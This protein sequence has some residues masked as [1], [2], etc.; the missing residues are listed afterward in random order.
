MANNLPS[1]HLLQFPNQRRILTLL[2]TQ[3]QRQI[4]TVHHPLDKPAPFRQH[5]RTVTLNQ[6][7]AA[8][9]RY[10]ALHPSHPVLLPVKTGYVEQRLNFEGCIGTEMYPGEGFIVSVRDEF[11]E[12][13]MLL[14]RDFLGFLGPHGLHGV[15]AFVI[16]VDRELDVIRIFGEDALDRGF[17]GVFEAVVLQL[18]HQRRSTRGGCFIF[19][20]I[21]NL[22]GANALR[23][24]HLRRLGGMFL[25]GRLG[26]HVHARPH[27]ERRVEPHTK[28]ADNILPSVTTR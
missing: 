13:G 27:H 26:H 23:G 22:V 1:Q 7:F 19:L 3:T 9:Q 10:A 16:E 24:P 2:T 15:D 25:H 18:D 28:L 14:F 20:Q 12:F 21:G 5:V 17:I 11:V 8:V 4:L 6:H